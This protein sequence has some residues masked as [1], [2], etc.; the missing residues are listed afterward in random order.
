MLIKND[1][2]PRMLPREVKQA[3]PVTTN[4]RI[5]L[6]LGALAIA[7]AMLIGRGI[8]LQTEKHEFLKEQGDQRFVRTLPLTATR[9][10]ITDRNGAALAISAPADSLYAVPSAM[11]QMPTD[12]QIQQLSALIDVPAA[13][14]KSRLRSFR[15][16]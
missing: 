15:R 9:G 13:T 14:I 5:V 8:Y 6:V 7:F 11:E 16:R 3:K 1:Y 12:T 4:G 2:K 10:T